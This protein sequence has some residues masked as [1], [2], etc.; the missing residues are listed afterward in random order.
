MDLNTRCWKRKRRSGTQSLAPTPAGPLLAV[1][2]VAT[3]ALTAALPQHLEG[4][5]AGQAV[6]L[7]GTPAGRTGLVAG[8]RQIATS[9][10][11][12]QEKGLVSFAWKSFEIYKE[13]VG[14]FITKPL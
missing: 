5:S 10:N 8:C 1:K 9:V 13:D 14:S 11:H 2:A 7:Q 3:V 6:L 4:V 12:L